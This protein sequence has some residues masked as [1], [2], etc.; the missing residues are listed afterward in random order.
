MGFRY[1]LISSEVGR[2]GGHWEIRGTK[3]PCSTLQRVWGVGLWPFA[4]VLIGGAVP[5]LGCASLGTPNWRH[6]GT[7]QSQQ[8]R[9]HQFDPYPED[10]LGPPVEGARPME[11]LHPPWDIQRARPHELR[12]RWFGWQTQPAPAVPSPPG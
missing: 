8:M 6:P 4:V 11:F 3:A 2:P 7:A 10:D 5:L 12:R 1:Q 9:A